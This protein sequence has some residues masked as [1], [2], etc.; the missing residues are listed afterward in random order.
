MA[1]KKSIS[2]SKQISLGE[3]QHV[4]YGFCRVKPNSW[5]DFVLG[6]V[7]V[8]TAPSES[9]AVILAHISANSSN[10]T[11][12]RA[13]GHVGAADSGRLCERELHPPPAPGSPGHI[14]RNTPAEPD[15]WHGRGNRKEPCEMFRSHPTSC[16]E[17]PGLPRQGSRFFPPPKKPLLWCFHLKLAVNSISWPALGIRW[18][19][20]CQARVLSTTSLTNSFILVLK[21]RENKTKPPHTHKRERNRNCSNI[22]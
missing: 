18:E 11:R 21:K 5:S 10:K 1:P 22:Q 8:K 7:S 16:K 15:S 9:S 4:T 2:E 13:L 6:K 20:I 17:T 12:F 14:I 19:R 3:R